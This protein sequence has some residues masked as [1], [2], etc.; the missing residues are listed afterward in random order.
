MNFKNVK[1]FFIILLT[2][3][4][5][6][7]LFGLLYSGNANARIDEETVSNITSILS[8]NGIS[9][10]NQTIPR[11]VY[12]SGI[13]EIPFDS[14]YYERVA[15]AVSA[16][17][18]E[19][20]NIMPDN[21]IR[22]IMT[23]GDSYNLNSRFGFEFSLSDTQTLSASEYK[24]MLLSEE[25][26]KAADLSPASLSSK[27]KKLVTKLLYPEKLNY[28]D[29]EFSFNISS[30]Y[31]GNGYKLAVCDQT[32]EGAGIH[33]HRM[34]VEIK[35]SQITRA[36]GTW[37]FPE[38]TEKYSYE[39]YD[40]LSVLFEEIDRKKLREQTG[41][42]VDA[43]TITDMNFTYCIYWNSRQDGLYFIP[44]WKIATDSGETRVY[45]AVNCEL[46]E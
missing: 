26:I 16:C 9:A 13:I 46:Y 3:V 37:F 33:S 4:N 24:A 40:Q 11:E 21:N 7:L 39:L 12:S 32:I 25:S 2:A 10:N 18:R 28:T 1:I 42:T 44:A 29:S 22:L 8:E 23:N 43:Y 36:S 35:D 19:S 31:A 41:N 6:L 34:Y 20:I 27:E 30:V 14:G 38:I 45:N 15:S 5:L 17:E